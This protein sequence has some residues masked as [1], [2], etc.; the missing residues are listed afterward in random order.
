MTEIA[1]RSAQHTSVQ[2]YLQNCNYHKYPRSVRRPEC[3]T[4]FRDSEA[5]SRGSPHDEK[6]RIITPMAIYYKLSIANSGS[7]VTAIDHLVGLSARAVRSISKCRV[8]R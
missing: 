2:N 5:K 8:V 1:D 6:V 3:K 4:L 7:I